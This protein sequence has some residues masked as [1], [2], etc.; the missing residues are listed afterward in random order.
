MDAEIEV[1]KPMPLI[2]VKVIKPIS[3]LS[4]LATYTVFS[5]SHD[6]HITVPKLTTDVKVAI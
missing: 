4:I 3:L 1:G 6:S 5:Q 2:H